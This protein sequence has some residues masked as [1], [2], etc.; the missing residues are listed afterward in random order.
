MIA[1]ST[2]KR[3]ARG[4][5][6]SAQ[7][8]SYKLNIPFSRDSIIPIQ[9]SLQDLDSLSLRRNLTDIMFIF[10]IIN[11]FILC[12]E[13]LVM[14]GLRIS[15][16][17]TRNLDLFVIPHYRT[18]SGA[19]SF[20]PRTLRLANLISHHLDFLILLVPIAHRIYS[21]NK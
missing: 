6:T 16:L 4:V 20:L 3:S 21:I 11:G 10:D 18:N 5:T 13:L 8:K 9:E 12:P 1:D 7:Y 17:Y 15:R 19:F 14:I 2:E